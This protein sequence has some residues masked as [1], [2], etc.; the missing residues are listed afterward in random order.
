[1]VRTLI[2]DDEQHCIDRINELI[3]PYKQKY[4]VVGTANTVQEGLLFTY[5]FKPDLVF[6]DIQ[7]ADKTGFDYLKQCKQID[8]NIIF[9]TA[10]EKYAI[11]AFK[12]SALDFLLKPIEQEA[13]DMAI[14]KHEDTFTLR[15]I[16]EKLNVLLYNLREK[17]LNRI[18]IPTIN[19]VDFVNLD[20]ILYLQADVNYTNIV[21]KNNKRIIVS[22][23]LKSYENLLSDSNFFRVHN[24]YLI[25]LEHVKKYTKGKGGYITMANKDI[26][27]VS[28]RRKEAFLKMMLNN[29]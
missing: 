17:S 10:Y 6:L 20:Q 23:T 15:E 29:F 18:C 1:M 14:K 28:H 5:N 22:R 13:F 7:I 21:L 25:N 3:Y 4:E 8:F 24:S 16:N 12:F 27:D 26:I 11:E 2:I 9:T 19:G